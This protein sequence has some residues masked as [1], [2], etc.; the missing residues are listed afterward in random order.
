MQMSSSEKKKT[1]QS[2]FLHILNCSIAA[3]ADVY[4]KWGMLDSIVLGK[5]IHLHK[6]DIFLDLIYLFVST[7]SIVV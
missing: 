7:R 5:V 6:D 4:F 2:V 3:R 1:F